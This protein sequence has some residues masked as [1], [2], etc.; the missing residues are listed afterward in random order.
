MS[1]QNSRQAECR[2]AASV[3]LEHKSRVFKR[4]DLALMF[5][6]DRPFF[7]S[8]QRARETKRG[9]KKLKSKRKPH[10]LEREKRGKCLTFLCSSCFSNSRCNF[11]FTIKHL[12]H[13]HAQI[14]QLLILIFL[15]LMIFPVL[16]TPL[17]AHLHACCGQNQENSLFLRLILNSISQQINK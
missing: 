5:R 3:R 7:L 8:R 1:R 10:E 16:L 2:C 17:I 14:V 4:I 13:K 12:S 9:E 11:S 15:M 6:I